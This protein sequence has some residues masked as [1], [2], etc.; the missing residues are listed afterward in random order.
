VPGKTMFDKICHLRDCEDGL[1]KFL[2]FEP[3]GADVHSDNL[4]LPS[5]HPKAQLGQYGLDPDD[6][7]PEGYTLS[8]TWLRTVTSLQK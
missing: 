4:L 8:D 2:L 1:R 6:P 5:S 3:R 7:F